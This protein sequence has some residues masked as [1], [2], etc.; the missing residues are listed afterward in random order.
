MGLV[1]SNPRVWVGLFLLVAI[2]QSSCA[3]RTGAVDPGKKKIMVLGIDGMDPKILGRL[4]NEGKL[5]NFEKLIAEGDFKPLQT[6]MPPQSPVAWSNF[7][8]GMNPGG[9]G[10][11]DFIHRDPKTMEAYFST[12]RT[13]EP[14]RVLSLGDWRIPLSGGQVHLLRRGRAFWEI[15]REHGV[16]VT[17]FR[18]PANFPPVKTKARQLSGMGTPDVQGTYGT[19]SYFTE[20]PIGR[21]EG[22][23]GGEAFAV[24]RINQR[25]EARIPGPPN[26]FRKDHP[27]TYADFTVLIDSEN[28]VA[29]IQIQDQQ[30]LLKE[31]SWSDWVKV[32]FD[33]I[34][35]LQSV[36]GICRFYLKEVHP[37]FKLY[38][39]PVNLDPSAPALPISSP[40][41]YSE[42]LC[43]AIGLF[44]TQGI[45]EDTKAL[46]AAILD[47]GEFLQQTRLVFEEEVKMLDYELARFQSGVLFFYF[48]RVD[49]LGHMFWRTMDERHPAHETQAYSKVIEQTYREMDSV[50]GRVRKRIGNQATL[51]VLSDHGFAPFYRAFHLNSWLRM[52]G[53]VSLLDFSE[54]SMLNNVDWANTRAYGLGFNGLYVNL[55]GRERQGIV[56]PGKE[57]ESLLAEL[58]TKLLNLKDPNNG[59]PVVTK[60]YRAEEIYSGP[61]L[62]E[63]PDL[64]IGYNSSYRASWETTLGKFPRELFRDN[65]EKWSGDHLILADFVPGILISNRKIQSQSPALFDLA[66]TLL[67]EYGIARESSMVGAN[68]F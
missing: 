27:R 65:N 13:E 49:Q 15:L 57:R 19:F 41:A 14:S 33:V 25:I 52:N 66:P 29:K 30:I 10:I 44:Y 9:H 4:V 50:L 1:S 68:V 58:T 6:S 60:V 53:Y 48:G 42:E 56:E 22:L 17:V 26:T 55:K 12:A 34:P 7:I 23:S 8:T 64:I 21:Y 36:E 18:I 5:P 31:K 47:D 35:L 59:E 43:E 20:E 24:Q 40:E 28:P 61:F 32:R 2:F 46:S 39:S 45:P 11:F 38:V 54:G 62:K 51:L 16:P 63:A 37:Q 67:A 3:S